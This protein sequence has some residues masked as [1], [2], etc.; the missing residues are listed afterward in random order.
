MQGLRDLLLRRKKAGRAC[1]FRVR[2][3]VQAVL[4]VGFFVVG[5]AMLPALWFSYVLARMYLVVESFRSLGRLPDSA[6][7]TPAWPAYLPHIN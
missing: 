5:W 3:R 1:R 6:F 4:W 7:E 2:E